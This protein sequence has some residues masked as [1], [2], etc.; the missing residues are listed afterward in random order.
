MRLTALFLKGCLLPE[1][2]SATFSYKDCL[3]HS[4]NFMKH[5]MERRIN[6]LLL[7]LVIVLATF[8]AMDNGTAATSGWTAIGT[9]HDQEVAYYL[10][11]Q[12]IRK[13][14]QKVTVWEMLDFDAPQMVGESRQKY[15]SSKLHI[16]FDCDLRKSRILSLYLYEGRMGSKRIVYSKSYP[17][18]VW[19]LVPSDSVEKEL[20]NSACVKD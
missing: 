1:S 5:T 14:G 2:E 3:D 11:F 10:D 12:S 17:L 6:K 20:W 15:L 18:S 4:D 7:S 8:G 13:R 9:G 19:A 16:E